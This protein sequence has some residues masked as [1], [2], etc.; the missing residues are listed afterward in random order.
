MEIS[1]NVV[2]KELQEKVKKEKVRIKG[3][4]QR[5]ASKE[6]TERCILNKK[7]PPGISRLLKQLPDIGKDLEEFVESK[8]HRAK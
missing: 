3:R 2:E 6:T 8:R 1:G 7:V 4:A 5:K